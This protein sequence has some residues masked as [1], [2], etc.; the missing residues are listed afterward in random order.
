MGGPQAPHSRAAVIWV[1]SA[2][3][4]IDLSV[5]DRPPA[6]LSLRSGGGRGVEQDGRGGTDAER[7]DLSA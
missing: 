3:P 7:L 6:A 5:L 4:D 2:R 1:C